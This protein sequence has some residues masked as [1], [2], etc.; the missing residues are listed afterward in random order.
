MMGGMSGMG[1]MGSWGGIGMGFGGIGMLLLVG[2]VILAIYLAVRQSGRGGS[3]RGGS[4]QGG[5]RSLEILRER[6]ATGEI[7]RDTFERMKR[8]LED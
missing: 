4:A 2:L 3:A 6:Y 1:G 8:T 5:D 7:D